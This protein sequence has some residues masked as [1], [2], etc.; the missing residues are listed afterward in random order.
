MK[1][2]F[3]L[4]LTLMTFIF[5]ACSNKKDDNSGNGTLEVKTVSNIDASGLN[6][7]YTLFSFKT[8]A[9]VS[10]SDSATAK[11]DIGFRSTSVILNSGIS[12][13]G[14]AGV[15]IKDALFDAVTTA[16]ATGYAE[17]SN[18]GFA[19]SSGSG[20]GWYN[21]TGENPTNPHVILPIPGKVFV[22]RTADNK[23]AK[24]EILSY[25]KNAPANPTQTETPRFFTINYVYQ[26]NG[27]TT[28]Y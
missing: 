2:R 26:S 20:N 23:Y 17:D 5:G 24:F 3:F 27:S 12:G 19:I 11:W 1:S 4:A 18:N 10:I 6:G 21:Y 28:I 16:D 15:V 25:Y 7:H 22:V 8:G 14:E 13:P 9:T